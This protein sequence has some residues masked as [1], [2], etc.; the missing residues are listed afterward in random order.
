MKKILF[1]C[2]GNNF[3][4]GAFRFIKQLRE[5]EP[6][7]VKGIF[8]TPIDYDQLVSVSYI[9][10]AEPYVKLK[11]EEK[12]L[13]EKTKERFVQECQLARIKYQTRDGIDGWNKELFIE[14]SR[15]ADLALISEQLFCMDA[16]DNQPNFFM[17]EALRNSECPVMIVP[18]NFQ[19]L[20]RLVFAYDG[21]KESM[22][23]LKQ[24]AYLFPD[25]TDLPAEFVY[26]KDEDAGLIPH[27]ELLEEYTAHHFSNLAA[28]RLN[29][30]ERKY[31][32][33]WLAEKKDTLLIS[34][35]YSRSAVSNLLKKSFSGH[36]IHE[37]SNP[38]F[39]AHH[40]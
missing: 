36:V 14:E 16:P 13:V 38:V 33:T 3:P 11:E 32:A 29:F 7:F 15:F 19:S 12:R 5:T 25:F 26:I 24:F 39:I 35:S 31:F 6:V 17:E 28:G 21:R 40:V 2:D 4:E 9:P 8:S 1:L 18:E 37:Q 30:D 34:G 22:Y 20:N 27:L 10:I 23:A